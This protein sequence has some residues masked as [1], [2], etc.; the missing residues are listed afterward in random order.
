VVKRAV[1]LVET[2]VGGQVRVQVAE[3]VFYRTGRWAVALSLEQFG[4]RHVTRLDASAAPGMP[5]LV[6]PVR[7]PA[8]TG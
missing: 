6:L 4:D 1:E 3:V 7:S 5:T 2:V 8:L